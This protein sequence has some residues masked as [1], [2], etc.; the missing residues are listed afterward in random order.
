[1]VPGLVEKPICGLRPAFLP[2]SVSYCGK[3]V[4]HR[5]SQGSGD[6]AIG[7]QELHGCLERG[8]QPRSKRKAPQTVRLRGEYVSRR[9]R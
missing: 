2:V 5:L 4:R 8:F 6:D 1:M 3:L 7:R 9:H